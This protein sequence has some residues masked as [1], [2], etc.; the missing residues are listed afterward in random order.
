MKAW[1]DFKQYMHDNN[2]NDINNITRLKV[3]NFV[4]I[5]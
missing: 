1:D 4:E 5:T 2:I 3:A